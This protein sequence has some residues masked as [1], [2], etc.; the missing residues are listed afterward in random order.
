MT[1]LPSQS[2]MCGLPIGIFVLFCVKSKALDPDI[3]L[4]PMSLSK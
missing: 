4:N 2:I 3:D 1:G